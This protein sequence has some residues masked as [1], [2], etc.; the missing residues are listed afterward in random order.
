[1]TERSPSF[2]EDLRRHWLDKL[3]EI[4]RRHDLMRDFH[5]DD[6]SER[7]SFISA[8]EQLKLWGET[9]QQYISEKLASKKNG[10]M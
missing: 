5:G 6:S 10:G 9:Q 7:R 4:E 8:W 1:M 2:E 3:Y